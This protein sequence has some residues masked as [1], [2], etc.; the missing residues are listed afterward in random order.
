MASDDS[1]EEALSNSFWYEM[2]EVY[3]SMPCT[4]VGI[5]DDLKEQRIN[6]Q[7]SLNKLLLDGTTQARSVILNV[8]VIFPST[9]S[10]A[11]TMPINK[12]DLVWCN[13]SMRAMEI[14]NESDGKPSTPNNHAKFDQ[15][16]AVA[17]IGMNTRR[18]AIN[19][20]SK[21]TLAHSTKDLA[22]THNIGKPAE[23]E[24]RF[25]PNGDMIITSPAKVTVN[26]VDAVVNASNS[27]HLTSP[28]LAVDVPATTWTGNITHIGNVTQTGNNTVTGNL[29]QSGVVAITGATSVTGALTAT[30]V[31]SPTITGAGKDLG[32]H[33]HNILETNSTSTPHPTTAPN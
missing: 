24:I 26:A 19:N 32:T 18:T 14:F 5:V 8:P 31:T 28:Q 17:F 15:K 1:G 27:A 33:T 22:I 10:S 25:K 7:P 4:V 23:V 21:R 16:D 12:G 29:T 30:S 20:S 13:F 3:T 9:S 6:V 2:N 11:I